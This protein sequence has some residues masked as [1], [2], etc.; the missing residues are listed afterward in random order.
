VRETRRAPTRAS[1]T[2]TLI[3]DPLSRSRHHIKGGVRAPE[4]RRWF[5]AL[6]FLS[7]PEST[8]IDA[9]RSGESQI[10]LLPTIR[11]FRDGE[12]KA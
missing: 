5:W 12:G 11:P 8:Q 10:G 9:D 1:R 6:H 4:H 2:I 7:K 3:T